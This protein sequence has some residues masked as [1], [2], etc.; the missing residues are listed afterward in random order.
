MIDMAH[1]DLIIRPVLDADLPRILEI[2]NDAILN[3]TAVYDYE[4][5]TL[6]MREQW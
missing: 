6:A 1:T 3:T 2:Y 4:P 5:H